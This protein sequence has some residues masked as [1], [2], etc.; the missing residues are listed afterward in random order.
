MA[1]KK[2]QIQACGIRVSVC[3]FTFLTGDDLFMELVA[4]VSQLVCLPVPQKHFAAAHL[5]TAQ[6]QEFEKLT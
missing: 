6:I 4:P 1:K 2:G 3:Q 5:H